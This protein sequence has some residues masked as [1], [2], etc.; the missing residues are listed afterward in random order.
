M[1]ATSTSGVHFR[2]SQ[3]LRYRIPNPKNKMVPNI[4]TK[5]VIRG[6]PVHPHPLSATL[7]KG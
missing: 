5:S 4:K 6:S 7:K 2:R 3:P 1:V